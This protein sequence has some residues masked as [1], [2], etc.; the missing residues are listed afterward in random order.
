MKRKYY[1]E[2]L[3]ELKIIILIVNKRKRRSVYDKNKGKQISNSLIY[4]GKFTIIEDYISST[5]G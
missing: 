3:E 1:S 5:V 4:Q 2:E